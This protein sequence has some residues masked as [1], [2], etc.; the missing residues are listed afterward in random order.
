MAMAEVSY[1]NLI[2]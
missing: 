1:C 2:S